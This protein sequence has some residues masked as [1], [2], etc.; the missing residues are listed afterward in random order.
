MK[1]EGSASGSGSESISHRHGSAD[2]DPDSHQNVL[3][4]QHCLLSYISTMI[5]LFTG[6]RLYKLPWSDMEHV[7]KRDEPRLDVAK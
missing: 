6:M 7:N 2:P 5:L 1:I 4:P 3:D